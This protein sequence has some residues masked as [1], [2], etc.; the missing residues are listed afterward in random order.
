MRARLGPMRLYT[1]WR[2]SS[3]W[4]VRI[5]LAYKGIEYVS[6]PVHLVRDGGEQHGAR[7]RAVNPM[8]EVPTLELERDGRLPFTMSKQRSILRHRIDRCTALPHL[9]M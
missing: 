3:A 8:E 2:S 4:R 5:A 6:E 7:Y 1:Y 9:E